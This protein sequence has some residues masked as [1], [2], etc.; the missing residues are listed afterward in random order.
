MKTEEIRLKVVKTKP[1]K[2]TPAARHPPAVMPKPRS[3]APS[4]PSP[5]TL[6]QKAG[7]GA[8]DVSPVSSPEKTTPSKPELSPSTS[9]SGGKESTLKSFF[10][11]S[12]PKGSTGVNGV[13]G[14]KKP[15]PI[16][17]GPPLTATSPTKKTPPAVPV[18]A[19]TTSLTSQGK[20][21][22]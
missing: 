18:R 8:P 3:H 1:K 13:A 11:S 16:K 14:K 6:P 20:V 4:K 9:N 21:G 5:L 19:P 7:G 12:T 22:L 10:V 15:Q 2:P 17:P